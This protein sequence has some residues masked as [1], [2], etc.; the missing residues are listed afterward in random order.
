[1]A[2]LENNT[3]GRGRKIGSK[4]VSTA[5]IKQ[6]LQRLVEDNLSTL[7]ADLKSLSPRDR[8]K[9]ITDLCKFIVPTLK[10]VDA[11]VTTANDLTWL[12][13]FSEEELTKLLK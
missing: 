5:S 9:A 1:M 4:N 6:N 10:Q 11:E 12:D 3:V 2:F 7:D 13:S 8:V